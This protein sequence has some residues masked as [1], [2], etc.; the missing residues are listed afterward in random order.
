[1][2]HSTMNF[3]PF[4]AFLAPTMFSFEAFGAGKVP[5]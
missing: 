1:M 4:E 5:A 2:P 3:G